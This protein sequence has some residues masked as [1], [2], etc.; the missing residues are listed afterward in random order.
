MKRSLSFTLLIAPLLVASP[1]AA[2]TA[3]D[4]LHS[5]IDV[6]NFDSTVRPQDDFYRYV[7]G[8]WLDST[9]IPPD[10]SNFGAFSEL[11]EDAEK[12]LL[13]IIED[14]AAATDAVEGSDLRKVGDYYRA[15]MD[16][17]RIERRGIAP[18]ESDLAAIDAIETK[19]D[20]ARYIGST[21]NQTTTSPFDFYIGQDLKNATTYAVYLT[22]TGL[23][24]PNRE[25]Y[26][27]EQFT[28][29]REKYVW[30]V[31]Q[32]YELADRSD[33]REAARSVMDL[34]TRIAE[35]HWTPV[36]NRD[37]DAT[38]NKYSVSN[39]DVLAP[40]FPWKTWVE[41]AGLGVDSVIVR[42]PT[43]LTAAAEA[44]SEI[45][46]E[47]WKTYFRHRLLSSSA[48]YLSTPFVDAQFE[49]YGRTLSGSE[50][51]RPRWKRAVSV[52]ESA[53]G[54][55][56]GRLYV[57][58]HFRP[59]SKDRMDEL[60]ENLRTAFDES[61]R[62]LDWMTDATKAQ[63]LEKLRKFTP[64][65][66]YPDVWKDYS[67]LV[68]DADDAFGNMRRSYDVEYRRGLEKLGKP[69]DRHEWFMTPQTV[70]AYYSPSMNEVVFPAA[71]L[72]PPF[73]NPE[74]DDAVNYGAI[75]GVI[76]HEFSH[77]FDDQGRKSDG[78][79]NLRDWWTEEDAQEFQARAAGLV[80]QFNGYSPIDGMNVNG[81]LTLGENIGDLAGLTVAYRAYR[82]S[83]DGEEPPVIDG[84]TGDQRFFMGWAQVWRRLY[85]EENL[86]QRLV[87]D[88]HS[89][90][91]YRTN[92][93]VSHLPA[94]YEAFDVQEG[95]GM[96]LPPENRVKIW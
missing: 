94:F 26:F 13:A 47:D 68:V 6:E 53:L 34:E 54:E 88:P 65:I 77:G 75:G 59:E 18:I 4:P 14:A 90:S 44:F 80:E 25:Y 11:D 38:Y 29:A 22:Q 87:T 3:D 57:E 73:F 2:A 92:G 78:D 61:I 58:R 50:E 46:V 60:V 32:L 24:L 66:G 52:T 9:V 51:N 42:Q 33:G 16:S 67:S 76:G 70:N 8:R 28:D 86:K 82:L 64:K 62:E 41:T 55:V 1:A 93:I 81:E 49:M 30:Y 7:N 85:R 89:P 39:L 63:A 15:F 35:H 79:G 37:R 72:Q 45:P 27:G 95:D 17:V 36:Q 21:H 40:G 71:I 74:A 83:L 10:R 19:G 96:Y 91:Q 31:E 43:Y 84:L 20:L 48:A 12:N 23:G 56:L 69:V 5:G